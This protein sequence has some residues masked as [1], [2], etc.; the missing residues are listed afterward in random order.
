LFSAGFAQEAQPEV[1]ATPKLNIEL[2]APAAANARPAITSTD[3]APAVIVKADDL[4]HFGD[5]I[6]I[7]VVGS[8]EYDW[9][10]RID[11]EGFM[12]GLAFDSDRMFALCRSEDDLMQ[13]ISAAYGKYLRKAEIS[14]RIVDRSDRPLASLYGAVQNPRNFRIKRSVR[15][16]ELIALSGGLI[17]TASGEV[18][19]LRPAR[20][21]CGE[22]EKASEEAQFIDIKLSD[23][24]AGKPEA[25]PVISSGD[26]AS[27]GEAPSIYVIG[28][29]NIPQTI[30]ARQ[31][32]TVSRAI[33]TAGGVAKGA[34]PAKVV[35]YRRKDGLTVP[36]D[37][38]LAKI[39]AK[40]AEDL[41]LQ[42]F[43]IVEVPETGKLSK[44]PRLQIP[45][46]NPG[47]GGITGPVVVVE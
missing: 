33:A 16:N 41:L 3:P 13:K 25:N 19:I 37:V 10:G 47:A 4:V 12:T 17:D 38:D 5:L 14:V 23:L 45:E 43:D 36:I 30:L 8:V 27:V 2:S 29:V 44:P 32:M 39:E 26:I 28:G 40:Q 24:V 46:R 22:D 31:E 18:R 20:L 21:T 15:L 6:E 11:P 42:A 7:D 34:D 9:R 35:I 1:S